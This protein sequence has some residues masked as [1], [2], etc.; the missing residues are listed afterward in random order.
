MRQTLESIFS[1]DHLREHKP[2]WQTAI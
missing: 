1:R 2:R